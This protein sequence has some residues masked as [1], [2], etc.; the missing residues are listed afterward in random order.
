MASCQFIRVAAYVRYYTGASER[1]SMK[2]PVMAEKEILGKWR[3]KRQTFMFE[4][5]PATSEIG[6][7]RRF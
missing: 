1:V 4:F 2:P 6:S 7:N 5:R 3:A